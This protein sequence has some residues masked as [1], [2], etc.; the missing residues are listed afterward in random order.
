[1][2]EKYRLNINKLLIGRAM[3]SGNYLFWLDLEMTG[4]EPEKDVILEIASVITDN[5]LDFV[6]EGPSL[7][8][9]QPTDILEAMDDWNQ[10]HHRASGLYDEVQ[11]SKT[12]LQDAYSQTLSF[13]QKYCKPH[14]VPLCGNSVYNDRAFLRRFMPELDRI[15]HYRLIDVSTVKELARRWYPEN[16]HIYFKKD[17][18]HRALQDVYHSIEEL[19]HYRKYFFIRGLTDLE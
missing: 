7:V 14:T 5:Q 2:S 12:T 8:I 11:T 9:H 19:K 10:K 16:P 15:F 17:S 18:N 3:D 6:A 4:L 1:M 13:A